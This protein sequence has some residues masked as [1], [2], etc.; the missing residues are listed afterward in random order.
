MSSQLINIYVNYQ[1]LRKLKF[2]ADSYGPI[3][4]TSTICKAMESIKHDKIYD[5]CCN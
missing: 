3:S 4:L 2:H 5:H 1:H